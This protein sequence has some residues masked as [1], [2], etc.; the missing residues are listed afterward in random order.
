MQQ[1]KI[2][3]CLGI[4][5]QNASLWHTENIFE[6]SYHTLFHFANFI[7]KLCVV[8]NS[9]SEIS[10]AAE[11]FYFG[12]YFFYMVHTSIQSMGL[13]L[14]GGLWLAG[15]DQPPP[16]PLTTPR[17]R[18]RPRDI[19]ELASAKLKT[20]FVYLAACL[21]EMLRGRATCLL[22]GVFSSFS[23]SSQL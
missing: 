21:C 2:K 18:L 14:R 3:L 16:P 12:L 15:A 7:S 22:L 10:L 8:C 23:V 9:C 20:D 19:A 13:L 17:P 1:K 5:E 4:S 11:V 6:Y